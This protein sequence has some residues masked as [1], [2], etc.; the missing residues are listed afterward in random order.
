MLEYA[1]RQGFVWKKG[2]TVP[3]FIAR[4]MRALPLVVALAVIAVVVYAVVA[5]RT[6]PNRAKIVLMR[7][8]LVLTGALCAFFA[9]A[10]LYAAIDANPVAVELALTFLL[11]C[12]IGLGITLLCR[13]RFYRNHPSYRVSPSK[14]TYVNDPLWQRVVSWILGRV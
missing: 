12:A 1:P 7:L 3:I 14:T 11:P 2:G 6:S 13:A 10:A 4:L 8:F 9:L 5:W